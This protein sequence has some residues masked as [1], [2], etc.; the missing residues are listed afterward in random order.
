MERLSSWPVAALACSRALVHGCSDSGSSGK[1]QDGKGHIVTN[2]HAVGAEKT[3]QV[4]ITDMAQTLAA[5]DPGVGDSA[6]PGIGFAI[7]ASTV[8]TVADQ[9]VKDGE[10][11]I[12]A[13]D[14]ITELGAPASRQSRPCPRRRRRM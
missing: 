4:T 3:F 14:I 11:G 1:S 9:I 7:P 2:P 12:E 13:G 5:T 10:A 8:K 6:A